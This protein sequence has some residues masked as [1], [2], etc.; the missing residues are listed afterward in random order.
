MGANEVVTFALCQQ[1]YKI[2]TK[3]R[4]VYMKDLIK[5]RMF[6]DDML[7]NQSCFVLIFF[8]FGFNKLLNK[9]RADFPP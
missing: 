5:G 7:S 4:L 3:L 6:Y 8:F 9:K 2:S 1:P